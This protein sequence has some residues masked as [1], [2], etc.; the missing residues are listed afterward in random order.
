[1]GAYLVRRLLLLFPTVILITIAVFL[2]VRFIPGD[3]IDQLAM[4]SLGTIGS[5]VDREILEQRLGL[6]A[7]IHVQYFR[8]VGGI[9]RGNLGTSL[10]GSL[11]V[12]SA[13][14]R[15]LPVTFELGILAIV[16]SLIGGIPIGIL[17]AI[18]QNTIIDFIG[19]IFAITCIA[20]PAF[21]VAL[22]VLIYPSIWWNW[23]PSIE[24]IPITQDFGRNII[25]FIIPAAIM[26]MPAI[27][28]TMRMTRTMMLEVLK[29]DYIRTAWA[30][31]LRER[32]VIT[33]HAMKNALIP[34]VTLI[35]LSI[36]VLVGGSVIIEQLFVLPGLGR[37]MLEALN[38]R[39]Y[40]IV[41]G[42]NLVVAMFVILANLLVD[43]TYSY[44]DP[45]IR[46]K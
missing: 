13:I 40:P 17:S 1:M 16:I 27:G 34:V 19:R 41:S 33:R 44:L 5:G 42:V 45:R 20:V 35:G 3:V 7:P 28:I 2:S 14:V 12:T 24:Y 30:K 26:G 43:M 38:S 39:D 18:R 8:W 29:Q 37:L 4:Q 21:W 46:Y 22:L 15:R 9:V 32:V 11:D 36:P 23:S 6:D 25:Q 31:G 10:I